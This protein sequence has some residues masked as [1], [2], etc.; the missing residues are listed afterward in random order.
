MANCWTLAAR[1][2][3][4]NKVTPPIGPAFSVAGNGSVL[5]FSYDGNIWSQSP[6][7]LFTSFNDVAWNGD[8]DAEFL[9][10]D[11]D[12][13]KIIFSLPVSFNASDLTDLQDVLLKV[14]NAFLLKQEVN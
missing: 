9:A 6:S 2:L 12:N 8:L 5:G 1:R 4:P 11:A 10:T 7:S 14:L 13:K 3:L